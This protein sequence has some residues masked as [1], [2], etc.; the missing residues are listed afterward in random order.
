MLQE[1]KAALKKALTMTTKFS[2]GRGLVIILCVGGLLALAGCSHSTDA[3]QSAG[4]SSSAAQ[5]TSPQAQ[6]A[7]A[8]GM[9]HA[10]QM[11]AAQAQMRAQQA[12]QGGH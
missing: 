6:Q 11:A 9:E 3:G 2:I 8:Q 7:A 4:G 12:Q 10:K 1:K 5:A